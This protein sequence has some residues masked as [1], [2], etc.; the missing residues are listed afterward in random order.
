MGEL[1]SASDAGR[2]GGLRT[3]VIRLSGVYKDFAVGG[4]AFGWGRQRL[5]AVDDVN[6]DVNAGE[7]LGIVGESGCGKSTLARL[8]LLLDRPTAGA[9]AFHGRDTGRIRGREL[10]SFR[11]RVQAVLQDP[12]SSLSPR[13]SIGEIIS[14]P[15]EALGVGDRRFRRA[16]VVELM[17]QVGLNSDHRGRFPHQFSGGQQQRVAIARALSVAPEV[18]ILDEPTSALD[19]SVRAQIIQLLREVRANYSLT[20]VFISHDLAVIEQV[21]DRVAVMY[22]GQVVEIGRTADVIL[23]PTHPYT[24]ALVSAV[25][26]PDPL[27]SKDVALLVEGEIPN[28][29]RLPEG[30]RFHPRCRFAV[31]VCRQERPHLSLGARPDLAV[32]CHLQNSEHDRPLSLNLGG[33]VDFAAPRISVDSVPKS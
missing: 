11:K 25:P 6:L 2:D 7:C 32:A 19:V 8:L 31:N 18:L 28:P 5:R 4:S 26:S 3:S 9:I 14:E 33:G 21:C 29:L 10:R 17:E 15:M 23:S 12:Y 1:T 13:M 27:E 20:M 30:C 24:Q 16:R 22:A